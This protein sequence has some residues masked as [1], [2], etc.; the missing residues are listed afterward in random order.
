LL[1]G[2][3]PPG[4]EIRGLQR[5]FGS[6]RALVDCSLTAR[7]GTVHALLGENGSGKSTLVKVLAGVL[8]PDAGEVLVQGEPIRNFTPRIARRHEIATVFQELLNVP[9][10]SV[11]DNIFLGEEFGYRH[12][13]NRAH[14][15]S[16]ARDVLAWLGAG[17]MDLSLPLESLPLSAQQQVAIA[18]ALQREARILVLDEATSA[19]D[20]QAQE[21]LF[22]ALKDELA[23]G[24]LVLFITHR[25]NE[26]TSL[27]DEVTV[28]RSG[29]SVAVVERSDIRPDRLLELMSRLPAVRAA[30]RGGR[31]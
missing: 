5:S 12:S 17:D 6:T 21:Q 16:R 15:A 31:D 7:P 2:T 30:G 25:M 1:T 29:T 19:L 3:A 10:R 20:V 28:L 9:G 8:S 14:R 11:L 22:S 27:A 24:V 13:T 18:R 23:R 26:I 4:L